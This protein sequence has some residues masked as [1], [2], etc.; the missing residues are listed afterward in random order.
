MPDGLFIAYYR[1]STAQQG[2]SGLGLEAQRAAVAAYLN[3]GD[4][5]IIGDFTEIESGK[6]DTR[7]QL[8]A[9]M[10]RCRLTGATLLV[11]KLDRLSRDA[12]FLMG[13]SKSGL[14]I[15][16]AD[17]PDA[18]TMMFGIMAIVAQHEREVIS[19][20]TKAAL[21]VAKANGTKL[22]GWRATRKDGSPR[23]PA[24]TPAQAT[25]GLR[26]KADEFAARAAPTALALRQKGMSLAA[27][28][29]EL[30]AQHITAPRGGGW[31]ATAVRN[32]LGREASSHKAASP[33]TA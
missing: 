14:D 13:L 15:R 22:G 4:W 2:K 18:N 7:P 27:V 1:V 32:L 8:A 3:G 11:A 9:A 6:I 30:T 29:A 23:L 16:A 12:A 5:R 10:A 25:A 21:A 28:A 20:R 24:G 31:N 17:M 33:A 19:A 26:R